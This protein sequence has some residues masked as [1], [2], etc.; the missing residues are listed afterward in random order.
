MECKCEKCGMKV[1]GLTCGK[2]DAA[3]VEDTVISSSGNKVQVA[4]CPEGCGAIKS[5]TCCGQDM[6]CSL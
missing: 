2:C 3:L 4:K 6:T 5:P 1:K